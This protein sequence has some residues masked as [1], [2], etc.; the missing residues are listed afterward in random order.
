MRKIPSTS[1]SDCTGRRYCEGTE[2]LLVI[3]YYNCW[4]LGF[5][6]V[7]SISMSYTRRCTEV[8]QSCAS[9]RA[10]W[11]RYRYYRGG[12]RRRRLNCTWNTPSP[13]PPSTAAAAAAD[14]FIIIN[15]Y[16]Y[17]REWRK[18][19]RNNALVKAAAASY[20][21]LLF[22]FYNVPV[23]T[24]VGSSEVMSFGF[25]QRP[26]GG[27][28]RVLR[29]SHVTLREKNIVDLGFARPTKS[30]WL[31]WKHANRITFARALMSN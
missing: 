25:V 28:K 14:P 16:A 30:F 21:Q 19:T 4:V 3:I 7:R 1:V 22:I 12:R 17:I 9:C 27:L 29:V 26:L 10:W 2:R 5:E 8:G 15:G 11:K 31:N 20:T 23:S 13:R 6:Y 24:V 18:A